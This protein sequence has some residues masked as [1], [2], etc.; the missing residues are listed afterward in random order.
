[1]DAQLLLEQLQSTQNGRGIR[2]IQL[3]D[4]T[5][6]DSR[7]DLVRLRNAGVQHFIVDIGAELLNI[8]FGQVSLDSSIQKQPQL[9]AVNLIILT[10]FLHDIKPGKRLNIIIYFRQ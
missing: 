3:L 5:H 2:R 10:L 7:P 4:L 9:L 6:S 1:M 8:F